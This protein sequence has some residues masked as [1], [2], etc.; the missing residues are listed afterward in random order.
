MILIIR[1]LI[2][3]V[4]FS[5]ALKANSSVIQ[6]VNQAEL[7]NSLNNF[8]ALVERNLVWRNK[9]STLVTSLLKQRDQGLAFKAKDIRK[10]GEFVIPE[11][12]QI[13]HSL[14]DLM[15]E[16]LWMANSETTIEFTDGPSQ[17][18]VKGKKVLAA[19]NPY[20]E[21]GTFYFLNGLNSLAA[22][23][24]LADNYLLIFSQL[25]SN[26]KIREVLRYELPGYES[27]LSE[28]N[29][30]FLEMDHYVQFNGS[31]ELFQKFRRF[32]KLGIR[33]ILFEQPEFQ[34]LFA[35][36]Q[37]SYS[38]GEVIQDGSL[39][40]YQ[41][42]SKQAK[43]RFLKDRLKHL[44]DVK[45][46]KLS[47]AFGNFAGKIRW[48]KGKMLSLSSKVVKSIEKTLR[49]LDILLEKTSFALTDKFIP[50]HFG[51][52]AL[53]IGSKLDLQSLGL[54]DH[55]LVRPFQSRIEQGRGVV[56]ALRPGVQINTFQNFMNIDDLAV[57]RLKQKLS[58]NQIKQYILLALA[59]IGKDYDFNFD[60]ETP[61]KLI[62]SE[63][64]YMVY[65]D[66]EWEVD[67]TLGRYT[68]SPEHVAKRALAAEPF[69]LEL[70]YHNGREVLQDKEDLFASFIKVSK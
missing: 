42:L 24:L 18:Q 8:Q 27:F 1:V 16:N 62:C 47:K 31:I 55:P 4:V 52:V 56:E 34:Y 38:L 14:L 23:T 45:I 59:Q 17:I 46:Y 9:T 20:D 53:W 65:E 32:Y 13:Q 25:Q 29:K 26:Q 61:S 7:T 21:K 37:Q 28:L 63:L 51:H 67:K 64:V 30:L 3:T 69:S 49:P 44:R 41:Q 12:L 5:I 43:Q 66:F 11:Y 22:S 15:Q 58:Q 48:G 50:G 70:L 10:L 36:I 57:L 19:L 54:W 35:L 33:E 6:P 60:V 68:I 40:Q 39:A 2:L